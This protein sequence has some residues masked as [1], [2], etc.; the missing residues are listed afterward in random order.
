MDSESN[1][2]QTAYLIVAFPLH[3]PETGKSKVLCSTR[4]CAN[5]S[6][7]KHRIHGFN[8]K[9]GG[10]DSREDERRNEARARILN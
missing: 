3:P 10:G 6:M 5:N 8:F 1:I 7:N 9:G 2:S 4:H